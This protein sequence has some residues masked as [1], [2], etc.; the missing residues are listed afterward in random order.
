MENKDECARFVE[1]YRNGEY[2]AL[3][4]T[5][6]IFDV[7]TINDLPNIENSLI[8]LLPNTDEPEEDGEPVNSHRSDPYLSLQSKLMVVGAKSF[9]R[10]DGQ[11]CVGFGDKSKQILL[12]IWTQFPGLRDP[13]I[14][15]LVKLSQI[16]KYRT[17]FD[18][19]QIIGAFSKIISLDFYDA[20]RRIFP[21][22]YSNPKNM[23]FLGTLACFLVKDPYMKDN[24]H[25]LLL[26]WTKSD[27]VW[28]W[29]S[30]LLS[31]AGMDT[32][33]EYADLKA[34]LQDR[35]KSNM[36]SFSSEEAFSFIAIFSCSAHSRQMLCETFYKQITAKGLYKL[37]K[38]QIAQCYLL[39][40]THS[41][42]KVNELSPEL[43]FVA[44]DTREQQK[45]L[46]PVIAQVLENRLTREWLFTVL[47]LYIREISLYSVSEQLI[48]HIAAYFINL[49]RSA[50]LYKKDILF[51]LR[52]CR[53]SASDKILK[54]L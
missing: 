4:V 39:M 11:N 30:A 32:P 19:Q 5:L 7:V 17:S 44:C 53:C 43:Y 8:S 23:F 24:A 37:E 50:P 42:Y 6:A 54:L 10:N 12:N 33:E 40:V 13:I 28:L 20:E 22:L 51:M 25:S 46:S 41:Y 3:A 18:L 15:W 16:H 34:L 21:K 2:L 26:N 49:T 1:E 45:Y 52:E 36:R 9:I 31:Y 38:E 35:L 47:S 29:R 27:S 48:R 14:S